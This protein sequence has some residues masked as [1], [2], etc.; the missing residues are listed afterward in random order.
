MT[1]VH[2][3]P[4]RV[5]GDRRPAPDAVPRPA[6]VVGEALPVSVFDL[7]AARCATPQAVLL[8]GFVA[9]LAR[10]TGQADV[11]VAVTDAAGCRMIETRPADAD[12]AF[13]ALVD[14]VM[15]RLAEPVGAGPDPAFAPVAF[16]VTDDVGASATAG[17]ELLLQVGT[18]GEPAVRLVY[19]GNL[20]ETHTAQR[21]LRHLATLLGAATAAPAT[22][23]PQLPLLPPDEV[24]QILVEWNDTAVDLPLPGPTLHTAFAER[25]REQPEAVALICGDLRLTFAEVDAAA[26]R[27]AHRL[28][29]IGVDRGVPV[30]LCLNRGPD[31]LVGVLA[32]LKAGGPYLPLDP[33]Y[34]VSRLQAMLRDADCRV[35]V[36]RSELADRVPAG[37]LTVVRLDADAELI[38]ACPATPPEDRVGPDDLCYLIYTSGSTGQ[39]KGIALRHGGVLN[40]L[41]DLNTRYRVGPGDRVLALSSLNFDM[42]VY[43][44]LGLTVGG[45]TVVV[46]TVSRA[47]EPA[48]WLELL[49]RHRVTVW[50]SAPSLLDLAVTRAERVGGDLGG[51]RLA[52]V[53]GDWI[54]LALPDRLRA[55]APGLRFVSLGGATEAS[56]HSTIYEVDRVDPGWVSIPYGRPMANQRTYV[57]DPAGQPVPAGVA[58]ELYLAG[59]GLARGYLGD[60][61]LTRE[62]FID[63]SFGPIVGERLYRTGDIARYRSDGLLELLGRVDFQVK[64]RGV[65]IETGEVEAAIL[66]HPA[67]RACAVS[68][69]G[70]PLT[71]R[72]LVAYL[73]IE[74]GEAVASEEIRA[75]VAARLPAPMVPAMVI[76]LAALP[77]SRNGKVDRVALSRLAGTAAPPVVA[78]PAQVLDDEWERRVAKVWE[79]ALDRG[80]VD[81]DSNFFDVGG[82]SFV[83]MLVTQDLHPELTLADFFK[84]PTV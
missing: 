50:N 64:I 83:A 76:E 23:V 27:L 13:G 55:L 20:F 82:D 14:Q 32:V 51:L 47:K 34:P 53:G 36:T 6:A 12:L 54:P 56:I 18:G 44:F 61:Q 24:R 48:H 52:L 65:R 78:V 74:P 35:L 72:Q 66:A 43:E 59:A 21:L 2:I 68:A 31:F 81:R 60:E 45:G 67:V 15:A 63:W 70:D 22:S 26:N 40:N 57:L 10:Y 75:W 7:A 1:M 77:L 5:R 39:P 73:V 69:V 42:S 37:Q 49:R 33:D 80:P 28:R 71:G 46:P 79:A 11:A 38:A 62:K 4:V 3:D 41:V 9:L 19:D 16:E 84:E 29:Q 30:G 25:A 17:R 8:A 58:G